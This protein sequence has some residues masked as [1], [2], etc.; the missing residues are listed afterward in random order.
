MQS[1]LLHKDGSKRLLLIFAGPG[2]DDLMFNNIRRQGYDVMVVWDYRSFHIDWACVENYSEIC[3]FA[4]SLG[5]YAASQ[6]VQAIENKITLRIA[7]NGTPRPVD[8][9]YGI[10]E[11]TFYGI[12][13]NLSDADE[14]SFF[15]KMTSSDADSIYFN[16]HR[17]NRTAEQLREELQSIADR[18]IL[19]TPSDMRW[20][21][22]FISKNDLVFPRFNQLRA[23]QGVAQVRQLDKGHFFDFSPLINQFLIKK[24]DSEQKF[25]HWTDFERIA[26]VHI[27]TVERLLNLMKSNGCI[28]AVVA[29]KNAVLELGSAAGSFSRRIA[30]LI[31]DDTSFVMWDAC[32][33]CPVNLPLGRKYRFI[34]CAPEIEL[35][36]VSRGY[37]DHIFTSATVH[38]F[39]SPEK[40]LIDSYHALRPGGYVFITTFTAGN[41]HEISDLTGN[42]LP[43][44]TPAEWCDI[45]RKYFDIVASESFVRDIDFESPAAAIR[46]LELTDPSGPGLTRAE[47]E[48]R[49]PMRLDGRFHLTYRPLLLILQKPA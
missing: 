18:L 2:V 16:S 4:W 45:A 23:W 3:L 38:L 11:N 36:R 27:D 24:I 44:L 22:A 30:S 12:L 32:A 40:F 47:A 46:Y 21:V 13:D 35:A 20:D 39:N 49:M 33:P 26:A 15:S 42:P 8:N 17:P 7:V 31:S 25:L 1:R 10:P 14:K 37:F 9:L 29:A 28:P 19:D 6:T 41:L 5:V 34:N 48:R 43:L